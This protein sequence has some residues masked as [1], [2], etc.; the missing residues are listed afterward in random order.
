M[1]AR[2][3]N[4]LTGKE[5]KKRNNRYA[6]LNSGRWR[7]SIYIKDYLQGEKRVGKANKGIN[8]ETYIRFLKVKNWNY[9][10]E[11]SLKKGRIKKKSNK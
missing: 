10:K 9:K 8:V 7:R 6:K 1:K 4:T 2:L 5:K 3:I 11:K